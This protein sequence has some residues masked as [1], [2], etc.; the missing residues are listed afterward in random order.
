MFT[1]I[2]YTDKDKSMKLNELLNEEASGHRRL[3]ASIINMVKR[4]YGKTPSKFAVEH[5]LK[6][7]EKDKSFYDRITKKAGKLGGN[8]D[9]YYWQSIRKRCV[10]G[11]I[12][13]Y[14]K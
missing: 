11:L 2:L 7:M 5:Y 3:V 14:K 9:G 6:T 12:S 8:S 4:D 1:F 10:Q 13:K